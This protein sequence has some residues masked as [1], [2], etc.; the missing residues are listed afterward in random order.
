MSNV[1]KRIKPKP[2]FQC[3]NSENKLQRIVTKIRTVGAC[4]QSRHCIFLAGK[5][6]ND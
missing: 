1:R 5:V 4:S 6:H 3:I 2:A